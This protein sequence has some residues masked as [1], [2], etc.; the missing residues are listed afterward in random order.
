MSKTT[1]LP[2]LAAIVA[3]A[4]TSPLAAQT[5]GTF[6]ATTLDAAVSARPDRNR[7]VVT[8]ALTSSRALG[9][10]AGLGLTPE[11]LSTRIAALDDAGMTKVA[12]QVLAGGDSNVVISTTAL[13]IALLLVIIL[14]R[15]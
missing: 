5:R 3:L 13:I 2:I 12:D 14:T 1:A 9:V 10:A 4:A 15:A 11:A 7:T 6:D 8:A